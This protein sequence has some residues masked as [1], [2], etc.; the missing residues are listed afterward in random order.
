MLNIPYF[1]QLWNSQFAKKT[2]PTFSSFYKF[3][4]KFF[5]RICNFVQK[6]L[7]LI[8]YAVFCGENTR[9]SS[10]CPLGNLP[11]NLHFGVDNFAKI[12]S[13]RIEP[14][15]REMKN[16]GKIRGRRLRFLCACGLRY[17]ISDDEK[18]NRPQNAEGQHAAH[19]Q[20]IAVLGACTLIKPVS[21]HEVQDQSSQEAQ[22]K[23]GEK[24]Q[25]ILGTITA[26]Y[27]CA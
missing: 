16:Y 1:T 26:I 5:R 22:Q 17:L 2:N 21:N 14:K 25:H 27:T 12:P 8:G 20:N 15:G 4:R 6:I 23:Q 19:R 9:K 13:L 24:A 7:F 3:F 10:L 11:E 18:E